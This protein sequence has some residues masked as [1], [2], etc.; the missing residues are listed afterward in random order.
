VDGRL[1]TIVSSTIGIDDPMCLARFG[2]W[3][4]SIAAGSDAAFVVWRSEEVE[5]EAAREIARFVGGGGWGGGKGGQHHSIYDTAFSL[6][7]FMT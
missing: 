7:V 6:L 5:V 2:P 3:W 4:E 1:E